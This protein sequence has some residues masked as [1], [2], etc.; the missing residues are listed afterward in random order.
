MR[1][2]AR[3]WVS[4]S[5][6]IRSGNEMQRVAHS[7]S[8]AVRLARLSGMVPLREFGRVHCTQKLSVSSKSGAMQEAHAQL[9]Q[10]CEAAQAGRDGAAEQVVVQVPARMR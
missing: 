9:L 10:L 1:A 4:A 7:S 6:P 2:G 5:Y 8:S 3:R